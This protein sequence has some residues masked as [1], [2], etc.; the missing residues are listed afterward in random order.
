M[1]F[2]R[3][4]EVAASLD[5]VSDFHH[6]AEGL[7]AITPPFV[8]MKMDEVPP[9]LKDGSEMRFTLWFGP[10]PVRWH[11][12]LEDVRKEGFVDLQVSGP[13]RSWRHEH[14]FETID[15]THTRVVDT[16]EAS[17][18][19]HPLWAVVGLKMWLGLPALFAYRRWKTRQLLTGRV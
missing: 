18:R 6:H 1:R 10:L 8:P 11:A 12:R 2:Q 9:V 15:A 4:F 16:I 7:E 19:K 13:F 5:I 3:S 17:L 14:R